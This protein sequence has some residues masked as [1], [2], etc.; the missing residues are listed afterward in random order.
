MIGDRYG[1][2]PFE[3]GTPFLLCGK[4]L[5]RIL[6]NNFVHTENCIDGSSDFVG[7]FC[8]LLKQTQI[9]IDTVSSGYKALEMVR[10]KKYHIIFLDHMMPQMD[11]LETFKAMK[12]LKDNQNTETPVIML[13]ANA[14]VGVREKYVQEGFSDYLSKPVQRIQL[15]DIIRKHLPK[16]YILDSEEDIEKKENHNVTTSPDLF[17]VF[18]FLDT[19]TG[20]MYCG[21]SEDF[22]LE[23]LKTSLDNDRTS[24]ILEAYEQQDWKQYGICMHSLKSTFLSIGANKLSEHAKDLEMAVKEERLDY[25]QQEH[26]GF[27]KEYQE[28]LQKI[29]KG[30]ASLQAGNMHHR[31]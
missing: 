31:S 5:D 27:L 8:G 25:V 1:Q 4:H 23:M 11:G 24:L 9:Q 15:Q 21:D 3:K 14:I 10:T 28:F 13:T 26:D 29:E 22:Y 18:D 7:Q 20:L 16:E 30:L 6:Q 17:T 19:K 2:S 12:Q